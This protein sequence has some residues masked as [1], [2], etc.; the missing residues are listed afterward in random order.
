MQSPKQ[1]LL[2]TYVAKSLSKIRDTMAKSLDEAFEQVEDAPH[3]RL[4]QLLGNEAIKRG[5]F[6][7][8][9]KAFVRIKDYKCIQFVKQVRAR[10][11]LLGQ[12]QVAVRPLSASIVH[13]AAST[14]P[15]ILCTGFADACDSVTEAHCRLLHWT[16][17]GS[18]TLRLQL[19]FGTTREQLRYTRTWADWI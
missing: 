12:G 19:T 4:W 18:K 11:M 7:H 6:D 3:S 14:Q 1:D 13:V 17:N 10:R 8:A 15:R 2:H 9:I 5:A 16:A